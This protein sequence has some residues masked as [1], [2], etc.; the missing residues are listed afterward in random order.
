[1]RSFKL[2]TLILFLTLAMSLAGCGTAKERE[3]KAADDQVV[4]AEVNGVRITM[5]DLKREILEVRGFSATLQ[6]EEATREEIVKALKQLIREALIIDEGRKRGINVSSGELREAVEKIKSDYPEGKFE[7]F[8]FKEGI[9]EKV[10]E[11]KLK[12]TLLLEKISEA[13]KDETP[14][15]TAREVRNYMRKNHI[16]MG[17][18]VWHP[19]KWQL[20]EFV[21]LSEEDARKARDLIAPTDG[22]HDEEILKASQIEFRVYDLGFLTQKEL[23]KGYFKEITHLK[24]GDVSD[25]V[26]LPSSYAV[27]RVL[28]IEE[29]K[30][31]SRWQAM[32][33]LEDEIYQRKREK[34]FSRW[35][36]KKFNE[37][38]IRVNE[39]ALWKMDVEARGEK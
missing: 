36:R 38:T 19:K 26:K 4:V 12:R 9:D 15:V 11:E 32:K 29:K 18:K 10:W 39:A 5:K 37:A 24:E 27:F 7:A 14:P 23:G 16:Y 28:K 6:V 1:M 22:S 35:L 2:A 34:Y 13:V 8:L 33:E 20:K 30:V 31:V 17:K 21:F 25:V 3:K